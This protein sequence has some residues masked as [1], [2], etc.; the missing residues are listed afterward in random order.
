MAACHQRLARRLRLGCL[1]QLEGSGWGRVVTINRDEESIR[2]WLRFGGVDYGGGVKSKSSFRVPDL[3]HRVPGSQIVE[4]RRIRS[5]WY[6]QRAL[7]QIA[8]EDT[9]QRKRIEPESKAKVD[10]TTDS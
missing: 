5:D 9:K 8:A 10:P 1:D 6:R 3:L 2:M 4:V 7:R